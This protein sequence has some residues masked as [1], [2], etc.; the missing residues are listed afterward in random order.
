MGRKPELLTLCGS[1]LL[2]SGAA[3]G[4]RV[5]RRAVT[6]KG[7]LVAN[8]TPAVYFDSS[9]LIDYW[10]TE[11]MEIDADPDI[12]LKTMP[13]E[14]VIRELLK[15]DRRLAGM[16]DIRKALMFD[17]LKAYAV[18]SPLALLEVIEWYAESAIKNIAAGAAGAHAIQRM[19]KK[20]V[21]NLLNRIF[22]ARRRE[23]EQDV[24]GSRDGSTGLESLY[25]ETRIG[26]GFA[27]AHGLN[28]IIVADVVGF[29][30]TEHEARDV[31]EILSYLQMG[32]ADI[33]H[34]LLARHFGCRWIASFDSDF[35]RCR[36]HIEKG[37]GLSLLMT[38]EEIRSVLIA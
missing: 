2:L 12:Q 13:Y 21:G 33:I 11:S 28:G 10:E 26:P 30:F 16:V 18:T 15:T 36:E 32:M 23:A 1:I 37:L 25:T 8:L 29:S 5:T 38:P 35:A 20:D 3:S 4:G 9:V 27:Q 31:P 34:L 17:P 24:S 6:A 14:E 7:A 19:G 22:E